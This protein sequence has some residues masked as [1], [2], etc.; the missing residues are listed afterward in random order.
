M[1][2]MLHDVVISADSH[3]GEPDAMRAY[4]PEKY[5][6]LLPRLESD[7]NGDFKVTLAGDDLRNSRG[8][9]LSETD[10]MKE[11]RS[12][13][14]QGTDIERRLQDMAVE[15]V[16]AAVLFPNIGLSVSGGS[17]PADF[18][19]AWARAWNEFVWDTFGPW[20]HRLKPAA[21]IAVDDIDEMMKEAERCIRLGFCTLFLPANVPWRPYRTPAY[22]PLWSLAE[23]AGM[24]LNFHV[25]SGNLALHADFVDLG[26][27]EQ[28]RFDAYAAVKEGEKGWPELLNSTVVGIA[29]GMAPIV[30]LTGSGVLENHPRLKVVITEA[31]CGWLAWVLHA[32]DLMQRQRHLGMKKL[33]LKPSEYFLRQGAIT[34]T[35]DPVALNNVK[36]TGTDILMWGNDYPHDEGSFP[37]SAPLIQT[38]RDDLD[39]EAAHRVLCANAASLYGFDLDQL[40]ET[41]D[42]VMRYAA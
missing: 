9:Q 24:P 4:L 32:M 1:S 37:E 10:L 28:D 21:M 41:R 40:Q 33:E 31:E 18:H 14:S 12:D 30:E 22:E 29:A 38:I 6:D 23:E 27:M 5:H 42:E 20:Q 16:D 39:P 25:F 8:K 35:D 7:V 34:I 36:F 2:G 3:V 15:G 19:H 17:G 11:F 26:A 13:P